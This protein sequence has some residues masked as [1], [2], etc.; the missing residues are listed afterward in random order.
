MSPEAVFGVVYFHDITNIRFSG[1]AGA[2]TSIL[3]RIC[4]KSFFPHIACV[5]TMWDTIHA[6]RQP[7][8][9][10]INEILGE[11]ELNFGGSPKI[12]KRMRD[13]RE[14]ALAVLGHFQ[15]LAVSRPVPPTLQIVKELENRWRAN[16]REVSA[17]TSSAGYEISQNMAELSLMPGR[18]GS[19]FLCCV[20]M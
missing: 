8:Y 17:K 20:V 12:F 7:R 18:L 2:T 6:E 4:G 11:S 19:R 5:T 3:K 9:E 15:N 16:G 10:A 14:C 1:T 13:D